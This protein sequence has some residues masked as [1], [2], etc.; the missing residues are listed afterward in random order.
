[1]SGTRVSCHINAPRERVYQ[2][3]LDAGAVAQ[4]LVPQ[5]M[6]GQVH[7]FDAREGGTFRISL[8]YDGPGAG[9]TSPSTDTY[10]GQFVR[11]VPHEP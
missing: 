2:A 1:M 5:G 7:A 4:W 9:K 8:T 6:T 3:L 10:H 11:L